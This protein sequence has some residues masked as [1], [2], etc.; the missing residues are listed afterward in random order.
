MGTRNFVSFETL[1]EDVVYTVKT[2]QYLYGTEGYCYLITV[3][4]PDETEY[5][6]N[7]YEEPLLS[8]MRTNKTFTFTKTKI[9]MDPGWTPAVIVVSGENDVVELEV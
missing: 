9:E 3:V 7:V 1:E 4:A 6:M 8:K 2:K 5:Y